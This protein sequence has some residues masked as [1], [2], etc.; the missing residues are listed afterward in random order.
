LKKVRVRGA[1]TFDIL[2]HPTILS[3]LNKGAI[4]VNKI[5]SKFSKNGEYS[6]IKDI[7][8]IQQLFYKVEKGKL[9]ERVGRK[10]M[11]LRHFNAMTARLPT[12]FI[13]EKTYLPKRN[14]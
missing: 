7:F 5:M 3:V 13:L 6:N 8:L 14:L 4:K 2:I 10:V 11:G 1:S 9:S 12:F